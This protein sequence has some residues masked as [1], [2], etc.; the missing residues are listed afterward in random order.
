M[1][2]SRFSHLPRLAAGFVLLSSL[3]ACSPQYNWREVHSD[4]APFAVALPARPSSFSREVGV[5]GIH[6]PMTMLASEVGQTTFAVATAELPSAQ[7]AQAALATMKTA[8]V[9]NIGGTVRQEKVLTI[10][11][12]VQADAG[13]VAVIEIEAVGPGDKATDGQ[14]RVL[15]A[16]F[17][18]R[19]RRVFQL[20]ATGRESALRRDLADSFFASFKL[21]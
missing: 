21:D 4:V 7:Q 12:S 9:R 3:V 13:R 11:R 20:L 8:M 10:A 17:V 19:D 1:V 5:D 18:A 15:F 6:V 14:A 2:A 16:R